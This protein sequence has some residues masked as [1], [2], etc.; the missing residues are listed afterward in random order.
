MQRLDP[1]K[2]HPDRDVSILIQSVDRMQR[3]CGGECGECGGVSILIQSVD[4][5]QPYG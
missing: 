1:L 3:V 5:M 4:R 2:L